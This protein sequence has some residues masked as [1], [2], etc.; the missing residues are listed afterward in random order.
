MENCNLYCEKLLFKASNFSNNILI[1]QNFVYICKTAETRKRIFSMAS[2]PITIAAGLEP[3]LSHTE[4][5]C[6][7]SFYRHFSI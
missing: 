5:S 2:K 1:I 4:K 7:A 6:I 3:V